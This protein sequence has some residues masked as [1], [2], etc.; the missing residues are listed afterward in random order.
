[1]PSPP[2]PVPG[3]PQRDTLLQCICRFGSRSTRNVRWSSRGDRAL[4]RAAACGGQGASRHLPRRRISRK[5]P[6]AAWPRR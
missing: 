2:A 6:A 3:Q 5:V 1:M 4:A